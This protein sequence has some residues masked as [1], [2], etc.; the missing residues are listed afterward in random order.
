MIHINSV[1][2]SYT[3]IGIYDCHHIINRQQQQQ[4]PVRMEPVRQKG[5]SQLF[6]TNVTML[7][8]VMFYR[9]EPLISL[10]RFI[11]CFFLLCNV[12]ATPDHPG[13]DIVFN[14]TSDYQ[15]SQLRGWL[16]MTPANLWSWLHLICICVHGRH[17]RSSE[18]LVRLSYVTGKYIRK[19]LDWGHYDVTRTTDKPRINDELLA[20]NK[21]R[22]LQAS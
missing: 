2:I 19:V 12:C 15:K 4:Q 21:I 7:F 13:I 14:F 1:E 22:K 9:Q 10:R 17:S 8:S 5:L 11:Q 6:M 3:H 16:E 18:V 20:W